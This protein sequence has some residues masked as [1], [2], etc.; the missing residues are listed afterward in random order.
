MKFYEAYEDN[1]N[2]YII[3]D[4]A[5]GGEL[6]DEIQKKGK[7]SERESKKIMRSMLKALNYCHSN[8]IMHRDLKP[9]NLLLEAD[10]NYDKLKLIDFGIAC[11]FSNTDK[12]FTEVA[13]TAYFIAPEVLNKK[14]NEKCDVWSSG[15]IAYILLSGLPPFNGDTDSKIYAKIRKGDFKFG[16]AF[17]KVSPEAKDFISQLLTK[18]YTKRLSIEDCLNHP[19]ITS[20][21]TE[22]PNAGQLFDEAADAFSN[23]IKFNKYSKLRETVYEFIGK[24]MLTQIDRDRY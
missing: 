12:P 15:V 5:R 24:Q 21:Q 20:L 16:K 8:G 14:Y 11:T 4:I 19:W 6:F 7:L 23:L 22:D 1:L 10:G 13:G 17:D 3:T 9:E 2:F 18:D